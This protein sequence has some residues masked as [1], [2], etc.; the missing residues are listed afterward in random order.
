VAWC[1]AS[2]ER[3]EDRVDREAG[4][5]AELVAEACGHLQQLTRID[6]RGDQ[7]GYLEHV[8]AR[9]AALAACTCDDEAADEA[10]AM[11]ADIDAALRE[12]P[13]GARRARA[14]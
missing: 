14:A 7:D 8:R 9:L 4:R 2:L 6:G 12:P 11:I 10:C 5:I 1:E 13:R 3:L